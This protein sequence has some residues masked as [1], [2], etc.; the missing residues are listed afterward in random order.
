MKKTYTP[1]F[2]FAFTLLATP[3]AGQEVKTLTSSFQASG[4]VSV[5]VRGDIYVAD[6]GIL[7]N[8]ANGTQVHKVLRD[9]S[10]SVFANGLR[11][12]SGNDFDSQGNLFQSNIAGGFVSKI[13]P[14]GLVSTFAS[15]NINGPVGC[16]VDAQDNVYVTN[17]AQGGG[18]TK[19]TPSGQTSI[20]SQS[21]LFNC[22]NG[23]TIDDSG[24][25]YTCNF[26]NGDVIKITPG[27][28]A[29]RLATIPGNN[30]GHL[31]FA[32]G[33]LYVVARCA[34]QIYKVSLE[35]AVQLLAGSGGRG[36]L[37]GPA[38]QATFSIPNGIAASPDGDTL[39]VNDAVPT[40]GGCNGGALN[41]VVVRMIVG[42]KGEPTAVGDARWCNPESFVLHQNYPN[43]FNPATSVR[44]EL[45]AE[46]DVR[47]A[48]FNQLGQ[49]VRTLVDARQNA[50]MHAAVW[51]GRDSQG[52]MMSSGTYI[53]RINA[54][55][56][57]VSRK[58][59]FV[60]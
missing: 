37:N 33:M 30:N 20:F 36:N 27:G 13:T 53:Y 4:G 43:P 29:S 28:V 9:G 26:G 34:N 10:V 54:G 19:I 32:N 11:G 57:V 38:L 46:V 45:P 17:C 8:N 6:F 41:P 42:V 55:E 40:T 50:G 51:D 23:L 12:A 60:K 24:T 18:I 15:S 5:D 25:L 59:T 47:L 49:H 3:A 48:V 7:L 31:T 16:V 58:M 56:T 2:L 44:Y 35:G 22:P 39:Y 52:N 21:S 14:A 1:L